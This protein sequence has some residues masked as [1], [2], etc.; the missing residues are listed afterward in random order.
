MDIYSIITIIGVAV[1]VVGSV[2]CV[3]QLYRLVQV[4]ASCRG[5]KH[6]NLWG[7]LAASGDNKGGLL[8]YFIVR[9]KYPIIAISDE[10][11]VSIEKRKKNVGVGLVLLT[12]GAIACILSITL[13]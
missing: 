9:R 11:R 8:L 12:I 13:K 1:L 2:F 3:Y 7:L 6:P 4:D 5:L 10:Q